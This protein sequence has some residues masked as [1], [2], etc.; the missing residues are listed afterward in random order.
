MNI[1]VTHTRKSATGRL[2]FSAFYSCW[3][4]ISVAVRDDSLWTVVFKSSHSLLGNDKTVSWKTHTH[5][6]I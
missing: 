1:N 6:S 4:F 3:D 2:S 5:H